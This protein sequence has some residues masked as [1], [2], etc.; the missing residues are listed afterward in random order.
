MAFSC[1]YMLPKILG[2]NSDEITTETEN[3]IVKVSK[4]LKR[5][6][7]FSSAPA[8][9]SADVLPEAI[10]VLDSIFSTLCPFLEPSPVPDENVDSNSELIEPCEI[11]NEGKEM[12]PSE[13]E[14]EQEDT[15]YFED[16]LDFTHIPIQVSGSWKE[17]VSDEINNYTRGCKW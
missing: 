17:F 6:F 10:D 4:P 15:T 2:E 5:H 16:N 8:E 14:T 12:V 13:T 11:S 9:E 7:P 1:A 3:N